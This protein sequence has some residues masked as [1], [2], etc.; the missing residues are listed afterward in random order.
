MNTGGASLAAIDSDARRLRCSPA[1][2]V[3][4]GARR[5][6]R[7]CSATRSRRR[8][9][10]RSAV[11][12]GAPGEGPLRQHQHHPAAPSSHGGD[13]EDPGHRPRHPLPVLVLQEGAGEPHEEHRAEAEA[14]QDDRRPE[15]DVLGPGEACSGFGFHRTKFVATHVATPVP[16]AIDTTASE[17]GPKSRRRRSREGPAVDEQVQQPGRAAGAGVVHQTT[18][19]RLLSAT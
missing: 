10:A 17:S 19:P 18:L 9:R 4:V 13:E 8:P 11:P 16:A 6:P 1:A 3:G 12:P 2:R 5:R 14:Q 7:T 15:R